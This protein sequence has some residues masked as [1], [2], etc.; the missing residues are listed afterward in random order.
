MSRELQLFR[1]DPATHESK[2]LPEVDFARLGFQERRDIQEW[3]A[4]NPGILGEELL[5]VTKEY[6]GFDRTSERLDLLGVDTDGKLVV[7]E[8]KRDDTGADAYW[9]AIKYASYLRRAS[10]DHIVNML[11]EHAKLAED[12]AGD[13]LLEHLNAEDLGSLNKSQR[14]ILA[15]HRFAP[16]VTSAA[17]WLN[18]RAGESLVTCVQL[19]PCHDD[20][21]GALYIQANTIIPVPVEEDYAVQIGNRQA[22]GESS[23]FAVKLQQTYDRNKSDEITDFFRSAADI[24][25][26]G[27]PEDVRPDKQS[28]WAGGWAG[29]ERDHRYYRVWHSRWP[30]PT[31]Q[32]SYTMRLYRQGDEHIQY[33]V[34]V[35]FAYPSTDLVSRAAGLDVHPDQVIAENR[36]LVTHTNDAL[37]QQFATALAGSLSRFIEVITPLVDEHENAIS[38]E[39]A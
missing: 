33:R 14:I 6:S 8:L 13:K 2:A 7:I 23:S 39:D 4:A 17:L 35:E 19:T 15:S 38:P 37:D 32:A 20:K 31:W 11:A 5:I 9:Q 1:I 29:R 36:I 16:E 12:E 24:A 21:T 30:W 10:N 28:R 27:L 26:T 18:E 3:V 25:L 34:T 22:S